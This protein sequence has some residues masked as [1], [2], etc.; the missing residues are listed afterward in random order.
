LK[1][2]LQIIRTL[3]SLMLSVMLVMMG[4]SLFATLVALR[5]DIEGYPNSIIGFMTSAYFIG[6][7]IGTL[8]AGP[9]INRAGHIRSFAVFAA[10]AAATILS[11]L[12]IV[13]PWAWVVFRMIMGA[14]IA[15]CFVVQESWLNNRATNQTRGVLLSLY[16]MVGYFASAVGQLS[17]QLGDPIDVQVFLFCGIL[18]C[19]AIVP[20]SLTRATNPEP[21]ERA[22]LNFN[23]LFTTSPTAAAGCFLG[24][25]LIGSL[26]AFGPIYSRD[27]GLGIDQIAIFMSAIVIGGFILQL[28]IGRLSDAFDR[29][30]VL[31]AVSITAVLPASLLVFGAPFGTLSLYITI[32]LFGGLISTIYPISVAYANDYL[33]KDDIV[34][35]TAGFVFAFGIGAIVGPLATSTSISI[36]GYGGLFILALLALITLTSIIIWRMR[37]RHWAATVD[38]EKFVVMAGSPTQAMASELNPNVEVDE[39]YNIGPDKLTTN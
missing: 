14:S 30:T 24:G 1:S 28:P 5:A 21:V 20:V 33:S 9:I 15:G 11:F 17:I 6:F 8:Q 38:K 7:A 18:L 34:S 27:L 16:I 12:L 35:S 37:V 10:I 2:A 26:W 31:L 3:Y 23:K 4:N 19:L 39:N 36:F 29:R 25:V 13:E 32:G 22:R